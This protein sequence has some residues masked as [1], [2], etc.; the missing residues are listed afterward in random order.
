M[1]DFASLEDAYQAVDDAAHC[2]EFPPEAPT[3]YL[4]NGAST[5]EMRMCTGSV[6]LFW[7][8]SDQERADVRLLLASAGSPEEDKW[9]YFLDGGNWFLA[10]ISECCGFPVGRC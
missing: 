6:A 7:S 4:P 5:G 9:V 8:G 10:D 2:D 3:V 1:S